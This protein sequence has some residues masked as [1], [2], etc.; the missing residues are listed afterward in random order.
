V[1]ATT[2]AGTEVDGK[3]NVPT[4]ISQVGIEIVP[5]D[6]TGDINNYTLIYVT[7]NENLA[8]AFQ[9]TGLPVVFDRTIT[10]EFTYDSTGK[11]GELYVEVGG[12]DLPAYFFTGTETDPAGAG[13]DFKANWWF[14]GSGGIIKQASDFPNIAF[15][16]ASV[17]LHTSRKSFLGKLIGGNTDADFHF[18]PVRGVYSSAHMEVTVSTK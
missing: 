6:H 8:E 18:L 17:S 12:P 16:S 5:P 11:A 3:D 10:S 15:G 14:K 9:V 7:N 4:V 13:S 2:C 1:R